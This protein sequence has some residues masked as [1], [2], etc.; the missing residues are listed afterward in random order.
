MI[1]A[2]KAKEM[3]LGPGKATKIRA[4]K[5][6]LIHQIEKA[7]AAG[8]LSITVNEVPAKENIDFLEENGYTITRI[9]TWL[10]LTPDMCEI[11]WYNV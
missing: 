9:K 10:S 4:E 11:S 2:Q 7:A 1:T 5:I 8:E 3:A 6:A